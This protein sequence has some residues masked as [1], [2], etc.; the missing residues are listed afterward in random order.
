MT[1]GDWLT[2]ATYIVVAMLAYLAI[3]TGAKP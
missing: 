1:R 2:W 3:V